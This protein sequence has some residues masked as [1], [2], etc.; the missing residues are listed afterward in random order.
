M[1]SAASCTEAIEASLPESIS[2]TDAE[3]I[4]HCSLE[5]NASWANAADE[6]DS[7]PRPSEDRIRSN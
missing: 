4:L 5:G 2:R 3:K 1:G 7:A 6:A